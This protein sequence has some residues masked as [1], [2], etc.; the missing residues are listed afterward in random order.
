MFKFKMMADIEDNLKLLPESLSDKD[1]F[2]CASYGHNGSLSIVS[3]IKNGINSFIWFG[4]NNWF[5]DKLIYTPFI[6]Y[7]SSKFLISGGTVLLSYCIYRII[8]YILPFYIAVQMICFINE[9]NNDKI[10]NKTLSYNI[11]I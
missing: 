2:T 11:I 5:N 6:G 7:L 1:S 9:L 8:W 3:F 4:I 10:I